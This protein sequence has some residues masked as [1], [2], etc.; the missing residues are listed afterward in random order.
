MRVNRRKI[1]FVLVPWFVCTTL[2][3][4]GGDGGGFFS[5]SSSSGACLALLCFV[6]LGLLFLLIKFL[7][8]KD[9]SLLFIF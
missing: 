9:F 3:H 7:K 4:C 1:P 2:C 8:K 5:S 6:R